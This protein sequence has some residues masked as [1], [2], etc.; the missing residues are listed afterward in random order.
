VKTIGILAIQGDFERHARIIH[1]MGHQSLE[2]RTLDEL[3][4]TEA[5]IIPGGES[6]TFIRLFHEFNLCSGIKEY[7]RQH[8]IM[9]TCAG[10]I[11]LC[12]ETDL[13][14]FEP[15]GLIDVKVE[16]NAYGRQRE[17]FID[18]IQMFLNGSKA[19]SFEGVFIRA[20]KISK[21]GS[22]VK[23]LARHKDDIVMVA[24]SNIL[25]ATFHPEL[26]GN[27]KIHQYFIEN[28]N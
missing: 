21:I 18:H 1:S 12:S 26:T 17:S 24:N 6:T 13:L 8:P 28:L 9:G 4:K 27:P 20:P 22:T 25:A 16:R 19:E 3:K 11:V 23:V 14:P 10:L 7:A 2:V 15:L 5:L